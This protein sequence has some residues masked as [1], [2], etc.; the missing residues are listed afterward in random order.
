MIFLKHRVW[1]LIPGSWTPIN[2]HWRKTENKKMVAPSTGIEEKNK[3]N[4]W[5]HR[6]MQTVRLYQVAILRLSTTT[7]IRRKQRSK[8]RKSRTSNHFWAL[9]VVGDGTIAAIRPPDKTLSEKT[10]SGKKNKL[11]KGWIHV[12]WFSFPWS[13]REALSPQVAYLTHNYLIWLWVG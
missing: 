11:E 10:N 3:K 5:S 1:T 6:C 2:Q 9:Q 4:Q 7:A 12:L 13:Q 8:K